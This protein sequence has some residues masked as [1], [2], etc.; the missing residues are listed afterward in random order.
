MTVTVAKS[1]TNLWKRS[2][3]VLE[4]TATFRLS[5]KFSRIPPDSPGFSLILPLV[6]LNADGQRLGLN[7]DSTTSEL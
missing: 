7:I 6:F 1:V 4:S 5:H 3:A 2:K